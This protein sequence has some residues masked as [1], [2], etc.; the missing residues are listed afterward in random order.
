[1]VNKTSIKKILIASSIVLSII[2]I[3][4]YRYLFQN[5]YYLEKLNDYLQ[6]EV[7]PRL[8]IGDISITNLRI[9]LD[10]EIKIQDIILT[11]SMY[12][13]HH[14][15]SVHIPQSLITFNISDLIFKSKSIVTVEINNAHFNLFHCPNGYNNEALFSSKDTSKNANLDIKNS[16][17]V[18]LLK[19]ISIQNSN[20]NINQEDIHKQFEFQVNDLEIH[21]NSVQNNTTIPLKL[22]VVIKNLIFKTANGSYV[23]NAHITSKLNFKLTESTISFPQSDFT[24][25]NTPYKVSAIFGL[26]SSNDTLDLRIESNEI[27]YANTIK[28]L[29]PNIQKLL[30]QMKYE[31]P[32]IAK[33]SIIGHFK[34]AMPLIRVDFK[35]KNNIATFP[36]IKFD[37]LNLTGYYLDQF[38]K[39]NP[40]SDENTVVHISNLVGKNEFTILK[41]KSIDVRNMI[42]PNIEADYII[43]GDVRGLN[44]F[45]PDQ[46]ATLHSGT[47]FIEGIYNNDLN[48]SLQKLL[49]VRGEFQFNTIKA[50]IPKYKY[51]FDNFNCNAHYKENLLEANILDFQLKKGQKDKQ[52]LKFNSVNTYFDFRNKFKLYTKFIASAPPEIFNQFTNQYNFEPKNGLI[53]FVGEFDD[54]LVFDID[55]IPN[56]NGKLQLKNIDVDLINYPIKLRN[57][58][59]VIDI[60]RSKATILNF[61]ANIMDKAYDNLTHALHFSTDNSTVELSSQPII[62]SRF[63]IVSG[64]HLFQSLLRNKG[65]ELDKKG[66]LTILGNYNGKIKGTYENLER[67]ESN[68]FLNNVS[69]YFREI[70]LKLENITGEVIQNKWDVSMP[71]LDANYNEYKI[72][73]AVKSNDL[74]PFW[75]GIKPSSHTDLS[76]Y[77][78]KFNLKTVED[79]QKKLATNHKLDTFNQNHFFKKYNQYGNISGNIFLNFDTLN[80]KQYS[81]KKFELILNKINHNTQINKCQFNIAGGTADILGAM[82]FKNNKNTIQSSIFFNDLSLKYLKNKIPNLLPIEY[83]NLGIDGK[84]NISSQAKFDV[85]MNDEF[86]S[87]SLDATTIIDINNLYINGY[88]SIFHNKLFQ[89]MGSLKKQILVQPFYI[90]INTRSDTSVIQNT[91]LK[92]NLGDYWVGGQANLKG[93]YKLKFYV[94]Y[95]NFSNI[96]LSRNLSIDS[97]KDLK[98]TIQFELK[99]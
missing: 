19:R 36:F 6:S 15:K 34:D 18:K 26:V 48:F 30:S 16:K 23:K 40:N 1:M 85:N 35:L 44:S 5:K 59:G 4:Q 8:K 53:E 10:L 31:N 55:N 66:Q 29:A 69:I 84:I 58:T 61:D 13:T 78:P 54:N 64:M 74:I 20:I 82:E 9:N 2:G 50:F 41:A 7:N 62:H 72:Q 97:F 38:D 37:T 43:K 86:N 71:K 21:P 68:I 96:I 91:L 57:T 42:Q 60:N 3:I 63:K 95:Y 11:D 22:D 14:I 93:N 51:W 88:A 99:K 46:E 92:S 25:N 49:N 94:P 83:H 24:V 73:L 90:Q 33:A 17:L 80:Y 76:I 65:M 70:E 39:S 77:T 52:N 47:Y 87:N 56:I 67:L 45:I 98:N 81:L 89:I 12:S 75:L 27:D 28:L 79:I 32:I